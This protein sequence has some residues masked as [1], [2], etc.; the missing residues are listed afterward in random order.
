MR[1]PTL[2]C[3][4]TPRNKRGQRWKRRMTTKKILFVFFSF[5][6][7]IGELRLRFWTKLQCDSILTFLKIYEI[8][9][10]RSWPVRFKFDFHFEPNKYI[11]RCWRKRV[12]LKMIFFMISSVR[13]GT[14]GLLTV[15]S[16]REVKNHFEAH[17]SHYHHTT[18]GTPKPRLNM[19]S[20]LNSSISLVLK[21][22]TAEKAEPNEKTH[23]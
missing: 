14:E 12:K 1:V 5:L 21:F 20:M 19:F 11:R 23:L 8:E 4:M 6:W 7:K 10:I 13:T 17:S 16:R 18:H 3:P 9:T 22:S 15:S 2:R